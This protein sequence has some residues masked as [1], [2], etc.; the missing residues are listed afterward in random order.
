M[1]REQL[2]AER[3]RLVDQREYYQRRYDAL[4]EWLDR[5]RVHDLSRQIFDI[6]ERLR[7]LAR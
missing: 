5:S 3:Q 1:S 4:Q 2:E 6:D 7:T